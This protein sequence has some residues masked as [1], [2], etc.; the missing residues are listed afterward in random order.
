MF[1]SADLVSD[2]S[3]KDELYTPLAFT[4]GH[5]TNKTFT[6]EYRRG[7]DSGH[8]IV[9]PKGIRKVIKKDLNKDCKINYKR[10][11]F[12]WRN[13]FD[14]LCSVN[15][16]FAFGLT[17]K[18]DKHPLTANFKE[19]RWSLDKL[20][21]NF[22]YILEYHIA[23]IE[24]CEKNNIPI[25]YL[26]YHNLLKENTFIDL[27][28]HLEYTNLEKIK[29]TYAKFAMNK[30]LEMPKEFILK[31]KFEYKFAIENYRHGPDRDYRNHLSKE[32]IN[33]LQ[34]IIS[35]LDYNNKV[36]AKF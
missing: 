2:V 11:I 26:S 30:M 1:Y 21:I 25:Y 9:L 3:I 12:L 32:H 8:K 22:K 18:M 31:C 7:D 27:C 4:H 15:D 23:V 24:F 19:D 14:I 35:E 6:V 36:A 13:P 17:T 33:S 5:M 16:K 29:S 28:A 34:E 10:V 20:K